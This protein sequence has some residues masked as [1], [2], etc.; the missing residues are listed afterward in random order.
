VGAEYILEQRA[1]GKP[2]G[3]LWQD[4]DELPMEPRY[5]IIEQIV[6]IECKLASTK[7]TKS[8]C[9]YFREDIPDGNAIVTTP[10][11]CSSVLER[12]TLGPLVGSE[13]WRGE[14]AKMDM[15]R[16]PCESL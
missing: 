2:L 1:L 6:E 15:S 11:L 3:R 12:F 5:E 10:P 8:G 13:L 9:I 4:W 14:R 7:F 16:G